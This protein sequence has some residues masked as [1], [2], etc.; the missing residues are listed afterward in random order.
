[1]LGPFDTLL[2]YFDRLTYG[3]VMS[4]FDM[5]N[6]FRRGSSMIEPDCAPLDDYTVIVPLFRDPSYVKN[7]DW[8]K[9]Y[10]NRVL[11]CMPRDDTERMQEFSREIESYGI[12][13]LK[14][15]TDS[16]FR[17]DAKYHVIRSALQG[18]ETYELLRLEGVEAIGTKYTCFLDAD[19]VPEGDVGRVCAA[20]EEENID[21]ASVK[22]RVRSP[23]TLIEKLQ[24]IEYDI[25]MTARQYRP[26]LTS[27]ACCISK[28]SALR[29]IMH[30]HSLYFAA[31]DIEV[32]VLARL[33]KFRVAHAN[34]NVDTV[35]PSSFKAWFRQRRMWCCGGFRTS[36]INFDKHLSSPLYLFYTA[37]LVYGWL[38]KRWLTLVHVPWVLPVM[39]LF[40]IPVTFLGNWRNRDWYMFIFPL[41]AVIQVF[42]LMLLGIARYIYLLIRYRVTG[43]IQVRQ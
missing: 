19:S 39:I 22:V 2:P 34:F 24:K 21:V 43:R 5:Q 13:V 26:W 40:Y 8:L 1:M 15:P 35:V 3:L 38:A 31:G 14:V 4:V 7:L 12:K 33:M 11:V 42:I 36:V 29:E 32:G 9:A 37:V 41:Y 27:G 18:P 6:L 28:T 20:M 17:G 25:A 30:N 16:G 23:E 10:S